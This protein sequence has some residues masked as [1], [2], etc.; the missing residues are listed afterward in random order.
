MV[1]YILLCCCAFQLSRERILVVPSFSKFDRQ[2]MG[3]RGNTHCVDSDGTTTA[4]TTPYYCAFKMKCIGKL[5]TSTRKG[6]ALRGGMCLMVDN[7]G[8]CS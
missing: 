2:I 3:W 1:V 6:G 7:A 8:V 5:V 4:T